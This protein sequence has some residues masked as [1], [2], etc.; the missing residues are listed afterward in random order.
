MRLAWLTDIHL[1]F[2][3][4]PEL[5][6][7]FG[8]LAATACDGFVVTGD[9]GEAPSLEGFLKRMEGLG[10]PVWF[11]LGNH[12]FYFG[13][14]ATVRA[15]AAAF[16]RRSRR[17][18]WMNDAGVVPLTKATA[19]VGHDGWGDARLGNGVTSPVMLSD[20]V[21]I[22]DLANLWPKEKGAKLAALGDE[23]GAHFRRVLA[24]AFRSH[25]RVIAIT[26]VPPFRESCW[27]E[28]R[29]SDDDWL[30]YFTCKA[31]GDAMREAMR[32]RPERD[33][34]VLCGHTH[35]AGSAEILPNLRVWTGA[36][37]YGKPAV[38]RVVDVA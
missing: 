16:S 35:G 18:T 26:H 8:G 27:Y 20:F 23:A 38:Q 28:G 29:I 6:R 12:D 1:N 24:E 15:V 4:P 11:V 22:R 21:A 37:E 34:T 14:I 10:R 19:L 13:E 7:F 36:A 25:E 32:E 9:I 17:V 5:D 33:L 31:A 2:L 3:P 30:P